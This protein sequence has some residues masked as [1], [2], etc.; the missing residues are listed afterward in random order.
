MGIEPTTL[1]LEGRCSTTELHPLAHN[2]IARRGSCFRRSHTYRRLCSQ[3]LFKRVAEWR[4]QLPGPWPYVLNKSGAPLVP[5][6]AAYRL[7]LPVADAFHLLL[8]SKREAARR[9]YA[10]ILG[11]TADDPRAAKMARHCFRNFGRYVAEFLHVQ[12]WDTDALLDRLEVEGDEHFA[13]AE[14]HGKGVIFVSAHMGSTEIAAKL[15]VLY[16]FKITAVSEH[17][18]PRFLMDWAESTRAEVGITLLPLERAGIRLLRTLRRKEMV[19]MIIDAGIDGG[20]GIEVDFLGRPTV[21]PAGPAR[22][23]RLSGAPIVF[24]LVARRPGGRFRAHIR[25][26]LLSDRALKPED[27]ARTLTQAI[28]GIFEEYVR[29]YPQQWYAFRDMW[30]EAGRG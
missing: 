16:G 4:P 10:H 6:E 28:A 21:F 2:Y 14:A 20:D 26:P 11:T 13:E 25:A 8:Q 19:A 1:C 12:G 27:D 5:L 29:R 23:A 18:R 3:M 7:A 24:G 17:I 15:A 22:L 9:N 30:P